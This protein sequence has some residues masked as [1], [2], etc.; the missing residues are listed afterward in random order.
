MSSKTSLIHKVLLK[1]TLIITIINFSFAILYFCLIR[2]YINIQVI[3]Y[4]CVI[5]SYFLTF[6]F[7]TKLGFGFAHIKN[8]SQSFDKDEEAMYNGT[9]FYIRVIQFL[10]YIILMLILIS[11]IPIYKG[12]IILVCVFYFAGI[13]RIGRGLFGPLLI[14][15]KQVIKII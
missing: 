6:E 10:I 2:I 13:F 14:A 11:I 5:T 3:G 8:F 9:L 15:K 1:V 7:I 4:Y 12:D